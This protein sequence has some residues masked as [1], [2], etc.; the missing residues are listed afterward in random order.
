MQNGRGGFAFVP[1][2]ALSASEAMRL[3]P[4]NFAQTIAN[5]MPYSRDAQSIALATLN[6]LDAARPT[7]RQLGAG[8]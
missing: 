8:Q 7:L 2:A 3:K 5:R 4:K 1:A 6:S